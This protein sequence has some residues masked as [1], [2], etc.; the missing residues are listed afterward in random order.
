MDFRIIDKKTITKG[1][2]KVL[3][4]ETAQ[5][6]NSEIKLVM[7]QIEANHT[8]VFAS[9]IA[10]VCAKASVQVGFK[11]VEIKYVNGK[12]EVIASNN[13][14]QHLNSEIYLDVKT[15]NINASIET[16]GINDGTCNSIISNFNDELKKMGI[17]IGEEK[18]SFTGGVCQLSY[19][20]LIEQQDKEAQRKKKELERLKK[21]NSFSKLKI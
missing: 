13:N 5:A 7:N 4:A 2:I 6:M 17:K 12:L 19:S 1:L 10:K 9:N 8:R 16:I 18:T 15:N 14:G 3:N 21:L 20:K 11:K